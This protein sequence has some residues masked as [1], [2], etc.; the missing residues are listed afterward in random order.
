MSTRLSPATYSEWLREVK[1]YT[2]LTQGVRMQFA[3]DES[4]SAEAQARTR[5]L[6][7]RLDGIDALLDELN[8]FG[9]DEPLLTSLREKTNGL[10]QLGAAG[11][12]EKV[13]ATGR[14][15]VVDPYMAALEEAT[16]VLDQLYAACLADM[17]YLLKANR[18]RLMKDGD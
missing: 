16:R 6:V 15:G 13:A 4:D 1:H 2:A 18:D 11:S 10:R 5:A 17:Q 3:A 9:F 7:T 8:D 14:W 12:E